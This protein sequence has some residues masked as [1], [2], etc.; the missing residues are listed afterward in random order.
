MQ[1][2]VDLEVVVVL[3]EVQ[4]VDIAVVVDMVE[5]VDMEDQVLVV[6][7]DQEAVLVLAVVLAEDLEEAAVEA[8][9]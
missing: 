6:P 1:Q 4:E 9:G 8:E 5:V 7:V 3:E 2:A